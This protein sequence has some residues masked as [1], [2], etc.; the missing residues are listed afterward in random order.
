MNKKKKA[1]LKDDVLNNV[2]NLNQSDPHI[3]AKEHNV[4]GYLIRYL[5]EE[6][7]EEG[8]IKLIIV[9]GKLSGPT[10]DFLL[11]P[12]NKGI[13]FLLVDGGF[14]SKYK[15][16]SWNRTWVIAKTVAAVLNAIFIILIGIYSIYL[17]DKTNRLEMENVELKK[18]IQLKNK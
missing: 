18:N 7:A 3:I 15:S 8:L 13:F 9:T 16:E 4:N 5:C 14:L 17:T 6:L 10:N 11:Q 2:N 1:Q 12:T